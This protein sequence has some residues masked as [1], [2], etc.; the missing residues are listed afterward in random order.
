MI[1]DK[2]SVNSDSREKCSTPDKS[3]LT[4][5]LSAREANGT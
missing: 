1:H 3:L 2:T 4:M 5:S